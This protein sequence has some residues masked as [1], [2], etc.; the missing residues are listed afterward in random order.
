MIK[1]NFL[2]FRCFILFIYFLVEAVD[3]DPK[4]L[5]LTVNDPSFTIYSNGVIV[6]LSPVSVATRGRTFSVRAQDNSGPGSEMEVHLVCSEKHETNVRAMQ[7]AP[8]FKFLY[9]Q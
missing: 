3:C 5:I 9:K 7:I 1:T 2:L 4:T 8:P 6:A